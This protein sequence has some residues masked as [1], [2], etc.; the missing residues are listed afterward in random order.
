MYYYTNKVEMAIQC[1]AGNVAG[2]NVVRLGKKVPETWDYELRM[3][4][5]KT[6]LN[7]KP[8]EKI[9]TS[10]AREYVYNHLKKKDLPEPVVEWK[11]EIRKIEAQMEVFNNF[12][13]Q[14]AAGKTFKKSVLVGKIKRYFPSVEITKEMTI[15]D[16]LEN[17]K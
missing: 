7:L 4:N 9:N 1:V 8:Y 17:I 15:K 2:Y 5:A 6:E 12:M 11:K 3:R 16:L 10:L 13:N 14:V